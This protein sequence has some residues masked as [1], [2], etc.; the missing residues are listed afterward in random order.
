[1]NKT[2]S[3]NTLSIALRRSG[4][5]GR[6]TPHG[7]RSLFSTALN[8]LGKPFDVIEAALAHTDSNAIR[9]AYN[10]TTYLEQRRALMCDWSAILELSAHGVTWDAIRNA[11]EAGKPLESLRD[12]KI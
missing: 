6:C 4:F 11:S 7:F 12:L 1:V 10:R 2:L 8:E 3:E 5:D 9:A